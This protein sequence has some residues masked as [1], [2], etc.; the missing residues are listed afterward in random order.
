[1][2][3]R[4]PSVPLDQLLSNTN[5]DWSEDFIKQQ[6][7]F[8]KSANKLAKDRIV[9]AAASNKK[10]YDKRA[11]ANPLRTG[12][13]VLIKHCAFKGRHKLQDHFAKKQYIVVKCNAQQDLYEVRPVLGG[14]RKWLNRKMLIIDPRRELTNIGE[15]LQDMLCT[16]DLQSDVDES[17]SEDSDEELV[18]AI[19]KGLFEVRKV[20]SP[21]I[22]KSTNPLDRHTK[23]LDRD[24][25]ASMQFPGVPVLRRSKCI[26]EKRSLGIWPSAIT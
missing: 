18:V 15:P 5:N 17:S 3:G 25:E 22:D 14:P 2:F 10:K 13:R 7:K 6:A 21:T 19:P 4:Q 1:M 11:K 8:M 23:P 26:E 20:V 9:S 24:D 12:S 16:G